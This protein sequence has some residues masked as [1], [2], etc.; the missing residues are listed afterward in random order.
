LHGARSIRDQYQ[1][2]YC[3]SLGQLVFRGLHIED[4]WT[5]DAI[6]SAIFMPLAAVASML[7]VLVAWLIYG[8]WGVAWNVGACFVPTADRSRELVASYRASG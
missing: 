8:D 1:W 2:K 7:I 6:I 5:F 4:G 3:A